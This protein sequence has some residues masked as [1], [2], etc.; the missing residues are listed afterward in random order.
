M[1]L[2]IVSL[3][4]AKGSS[5]GKWCCICLAAIGIPVSCVVLIACFWIEFACV[6]MILYGLYSLQDSCYYEFWYS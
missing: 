4:E 6:Y 5:T 1:V 2:H 3:C